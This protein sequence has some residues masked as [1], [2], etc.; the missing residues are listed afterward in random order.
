MGLC[1]DSIN[2]WHMMAVHLSEVQTFLE[3]LL[4]MLTYTDTDTL[5]TQLL[6]GWAV[7]A[8]G[9]YSHDGWMDLTPLRT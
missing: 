5:Y 7:S 3:H 8:E 4:N 1:I 9:A 2:G 6:K